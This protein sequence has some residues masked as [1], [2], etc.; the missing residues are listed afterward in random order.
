MAYQRATA[1]SIYD[2]FDEVLDER[3]GGAR[4]T[5]SSATFLDTEVDG[6]QLTREDI[7]DICFLFLIAGLD[8]V[9]ATLDCM[10][11]LPRPAPRAAPADRRR[12][13]A[14]P[15][16][17]RG[18]AALGDAGHGCRARRAARTPSS[19]AARSTKGDQV[20]VAA[21]LGEHRRSR[22]RRRR[23]RCASTARPTATSPSAVACTAAS[24]RTWPVRSC[25]WRCASGT[26]A[27]PSTRSRRPHARVHVPDPLDR[28]LPDGDQPRLTRADRLAFRPLT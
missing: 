27:S 9:T 7:L 16:R 10:F 22:V 26:A 6:Q 14:H 11:A 2:Y 13:V 5:T 21:R 4:R 20:M 23:R 3:D 15:S 17:G 19:A 1:Q 25:G 12:P 8:T 28:P 18:A 24:A